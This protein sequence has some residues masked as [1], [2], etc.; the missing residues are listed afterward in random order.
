MANKNQQ[1]DAEEQNDDFNEEEE[2]ITQIEARNVV[3]GLALL[4]HVNEKF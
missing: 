4:N 2:A 3:D 1:T